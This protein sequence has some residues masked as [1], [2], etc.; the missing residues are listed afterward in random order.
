MNI[1]HP[2]YQNMMVSCH[3]CLF[4]KKK[5]DWVI[6]KKTDTFSLKVTSNRM[7]RLDASNTVLLP[8]S[9]AYRHIPVRVPSTL[10][11][12][13]PWISHTFLIC[14]HGLGLF[15]CLQNWDSPSCSVRFETGVF[16]FFIHVSRIPEYN[17]SIPGMRLLCKYTIMKQEVVWLLVAMATSHLTLPQQMVVAE[18]SEWLCIQQLLHNRW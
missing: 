13:G 9:I 2:L 4:W 12:L 17:N 16:C 5:C 8:N 6:L 1:L 18:L 3:N 15:P 7:R 14:Q 11:R 10:S